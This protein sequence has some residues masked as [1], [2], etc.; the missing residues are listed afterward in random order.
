MRVINI[1]MLAVL[2]GVGVVAC[3]GGANV[4][5]LMPSPTS[6]PSPEPTTYC[7]RNVGPVKII[8]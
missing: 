1:A 6:P 4:P 3:G 7:Q 8:V 5:I 2:F